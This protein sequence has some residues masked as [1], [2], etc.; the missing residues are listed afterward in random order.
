MTSMES[1]IQVL[2]QIQI[3]IVRVGEL[4]GLAILSYY[5]LLKHIKLLRQEVKKEAARSQAEDVRQ[6]QPS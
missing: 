2:D 4:A 1:I 3:L 5:L 6:D